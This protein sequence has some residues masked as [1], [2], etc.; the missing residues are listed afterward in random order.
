MPSHLTP[1]Q[2]R[3]EFWAQLSDRLQAAGYR[4]SQRGNYCYLRLGVANTQ[5]VLTAP[6]GE[7]GVECKLSLA[8]A[9]RAGTLAAEEVFEQL[10]QNRYAIEAQVGHGALEWGSG[11]SRTRVYLRRAADLGDRRTWDQT[12]DWLVGCANRFTHTFRPHLIAITSPGTMSEQAPPARRRVLETGTAAPSQAHPV[13]AALVFDEPAKANHSG[14]A[15]EHADEVG[16]DAHLNALASRLGLVLKRPSST[17]GHAWS[18]EAPPESSGNHLHRYAYALWWKPR[19]QPRL[20]D[21]VAWVL[22]NPS[23]G[24]TD[25]KPRPT[26]GYCRNRTSLDWK[27]GGLLILNLFAYRATNP[28]AL[29]GLPREMCIGPRNDQIL[30]NLA[31]RCALAIAAWGH[32]GSLHGRSREVA[33][34]LP[35]LHAV[36]NRDGQRTGDCGEPSHPRWLPAMPVL[37][38]L[39]R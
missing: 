24:D 27:R 23:T 13:A 1:S 4:P 36:I 20:D 31:P 16:L 34:L 21:M 5:V 7:G 2:I 3:E 28:G 17:R 37:Y 10:Y 6:T 9:A 18:L 14:Q 25:N 32:H 26:L 30:I 29:Y 11:R 35:D 39:R 15:S 12:C 8:G 22:L 38:R 33:A 19:E